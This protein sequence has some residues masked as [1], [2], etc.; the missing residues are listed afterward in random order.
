[1]TH[2][3]TD[4]WAEGQALIAVVR[5]LAPHGD[6]DRAE[7]LARS[8]AYRATRDRALVAL[9]ELSDPD[10]ARRLAA[11]VIVLDDW[12]TALPLLERLAPRAPR[13]PATVADHATALLPDS[14]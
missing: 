13:A 9:A 5:E 8:I 3:I 6:P 7:V 12:V 14:A 11:Q 4:H 2:S 1:M 10:R